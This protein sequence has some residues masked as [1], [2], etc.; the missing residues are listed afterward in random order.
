MILGRRSFIFP[1][2]KY[3]QWDSMHTLKNIMLNIAYFNEPIY[4]DKS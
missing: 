2:E 4:K 3:F 1:F